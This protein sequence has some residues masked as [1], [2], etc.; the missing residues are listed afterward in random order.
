[1][2]KHVSYTRIKNTAT[3]ALRVW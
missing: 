3:D 2:D 1:M